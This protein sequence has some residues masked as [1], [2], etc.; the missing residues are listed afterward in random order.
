MTT[1][2]GMALG[3]S[4]EDRIAISE[5]TTNVDLILVRASLNADNHSVPSW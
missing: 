2:Q 5:R 4:Y 1:H 3:T